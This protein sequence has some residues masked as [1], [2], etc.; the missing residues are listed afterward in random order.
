MKKISIL[1]LSVALIV[2][3]ASC[4]KKQEETNTTAPSLTLTGTSS[5]T[6][7]VG[8]TYTELGATAADVS[9]ASLTVSI[10]AS[11]VNTTTTGVYSVLYSATDADGNTA[12]KTRTVSVVI[13]AQNWTGSWSVSHSVRACS[14][15]SNLIATSCSVTEFGGSFTFLHGT[16]TLNATVSGNVVTFASTQLS[17]NLGACTYTLTGSGTINSTGDQIDASF[18]W[19]PD[20]CLLCGS[21]SASATYIKQ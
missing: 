19:A 20:N 5:I 15:T 7:S 14:P 8:D 4:K 9:G 17:I 10:D 21:G 12:Q 11:S 13:S 3:S 18:Q 16:T 1:F 6:L 2:G